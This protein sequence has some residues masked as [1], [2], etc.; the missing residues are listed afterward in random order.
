[1]RAKL[2]SRLLLELLR[3]GSGNVARHQNGGVVLFT[4]FYLYGL[5]LI[6]FGVVL[7][8]CFGWNGAGRLQ[9]C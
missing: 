5:A 7:Y 9:Q 6:T 8:R 4:R 1:M 2:Q 3:L